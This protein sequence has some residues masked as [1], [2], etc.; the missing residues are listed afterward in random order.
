MV[1]MFAL[2]RA[3]ELAPSSCLLRAYILHFL[4]RNELNCHVFVSRV[5][6]KLFIIPDNVNAKFDQK[7]IK[8]LYCL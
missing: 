4:Y 1:T 8:S 5:Q 6:I 7:T 2:R 3:F